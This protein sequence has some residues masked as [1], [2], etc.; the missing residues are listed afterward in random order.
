M[1][2][3][4]GTRLTEWT[5]DFALRVIRLYSALP[6]STVAQVIGKQT[7]RAGTSA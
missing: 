2:A 3:E 6:K 4:R 1:N 5:R 7:L